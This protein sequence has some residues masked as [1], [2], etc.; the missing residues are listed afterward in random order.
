MKIDLPGGLLIIGGPEKAEPT[1]IGHHM[2]SKTNR[3]KAQRCRL[4]VNGL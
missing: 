1:K 2:L 3:G 4:Q